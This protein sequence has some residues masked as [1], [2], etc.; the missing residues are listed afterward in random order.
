MPGAMQ[1]LKGVGV[2]LVT[3][4]DSEGKIDFPAF[5]KLIDH[6]IRGGVDYLVVQGTT[7]ES[8]VLSKTEKQE[9]LNAAVNVAAGRLPVVFGIGSNHTQGVIDAYRSFDLGDVAAILSVSPYY[10]KPTQEGIYQ[11]FKAISDSFDHPVILYN[12]PGRTRSNMTAETTLRL[13]TE[14]DNIVAVKEASGD[15]DQMGSIIKG[16]PD[17]FLVLSGD[18][19]LVLPQMAIGADGVIS[20]VANAFPD[21]FSE[22]VHLAGEGRIADA[23]NFYYLLHDIIPLLFV[24]GNPAGVKAALNMLG[25]CEEYLRLPLV[26]LSSSTREQLSHAI[27]LAGLI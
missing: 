7:G 16:R 4:F 18:D 24:E 10:N 26:E 20:V 13:A 5:E 27:K 2:A 22:M 8:P 23:R 12:V 21:P 25:I 3:P 14:C 9:V 1:E 19:N 17:G 11:H 6:V 15:L